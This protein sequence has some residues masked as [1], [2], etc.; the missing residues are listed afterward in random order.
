MPHAGIL[1]RRCGVR[2]FSTPPYHCCGEVLPWE[3]LLPP[4]RGIPRERDPG[5]GT[6][7]RTARQTVPGVQ[8]EWLPVGFLLLV[9]CFEVFN[10]Y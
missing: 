5:E 4:G 1:L 10:I 7:A 8:G 9:I 6:D 3:K 2:G